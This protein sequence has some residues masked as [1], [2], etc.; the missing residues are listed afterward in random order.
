[1]N[2]PYQWRGLGEAGPSNST[3]GECLPRNAANTERHARRARRNVIHIPTLES[4]RDKHVPP[5]VDLPACPSGL[6]RTCLDVCDPS[7]EEKWGRLR[8]DCAC[9][10]SQYYP[11]CTFIGHRE[12]LVAGGRKNRNF[13]ERASSLE[14]V[15][16]QSSE[17]GYGCADGA[18]DCSP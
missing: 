15:G 2:C 9:L 13:Q 16:Q 18:A 6:T 17:A 11:G 5:K 4:G 7:P 3:N 12:Q 1:V 10:K 14:P 8:R